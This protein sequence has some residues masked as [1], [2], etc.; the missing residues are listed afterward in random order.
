MVEAALVDYAGPLLAIPIIG[1][2][3][4]K[5]L[6]YFADILYKKLQGQVVFDSILFVDLAHRQAFSAASTSLQQIAMNKGIDSQEFKDAHETEKQAL[7][8]FG[9]FN[10]VQPGLVAPPTGPVDGTD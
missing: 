1:P 6:R 2:I 10:V 9:Q 4:D 5:A 7:K 3:I 8:K